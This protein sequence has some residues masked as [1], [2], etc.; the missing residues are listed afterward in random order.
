MFQDSS[1]GKREHNYCLTI[2]EYGEIQFYGNINAFNGLKFT[3][4]IIVLY[5]RTQSVPHD[6]PLYP[7]NM[8]YPMNTILREYLK[9][10]GFL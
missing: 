2:I 6:R 10:Q 8:V 3:K 4:K 5:I 1:P 7:T 9:I